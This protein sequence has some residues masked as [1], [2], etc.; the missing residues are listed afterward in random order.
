MTCDGATPP[1]PNPNDNS[2]PTVNPRTRR[3][4]KRYCWTHGCCTHWDRHCKAKKAGHQDAATFK[5][6]MGGSNKGCLPV[7]PRE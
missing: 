1:P 4:Y 5:E 6:R 3:P 7:T 2:L